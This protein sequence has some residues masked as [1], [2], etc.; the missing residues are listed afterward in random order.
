MQRKWSV[1]WLRRI[2]EDY[3]FLPIC[4]Q[5]CLEKGCLEHFPC[6]SSP[7]SWRCPFTFQI[8]SLLMA[9]PFPDPQHP[10]FPIT[11]LP[12]LLHSKLELLCYLLPFKGLQASSIFPELKIEPGS[13]QVLSKCSL[14]EDKC[15]LLSPCRMQDQVLNEHMV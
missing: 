6:P 5:P 10:H 1:P 7:Q 9:P 4:F 14:R 8:A 2:A 12:S 15:H 3:I 11:V 13:H